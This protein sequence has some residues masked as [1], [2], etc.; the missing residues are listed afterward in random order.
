MFCSTTYKNISYKSVQNHSPTS[1]VYDKEKL[2]TVIRRYDTD[3]DG[4]LSRKELKKAFK[5]L[6]AT[7]PGWRAIRALCHADK[8]RDGFISEE[9]LGNLVHYAA[10][11]GYVL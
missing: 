10:K 8:N 5:E 3:G 4:N 2:K 7:A 11:R 9:E 1:A 6:G